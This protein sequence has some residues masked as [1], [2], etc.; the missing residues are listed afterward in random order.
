MERYFTF[1]VRPVEKTD[2]R[3]GTAVCRFTLIEL[4][5]VIAIIAILAAL[6]LPVLN[7]AR[8][9]SKGASCLNNKK[10]CI[11]ALGMYS[12]DF[13]GYFL[14]YEERGGVIKTWPTVLANNSITKF[15]GGPY[16]TPASVLCPSLE[17]IPHADPTDYNYWSRA[18]GMDFDGVNENLG[19]YI[20]SSWNYSY[21]NTKRMKKT[22]S[23]LVLADTAD[24]KNRVHVRFK[25]YTEF[26]CRVAAAHNKRISAAFADGS[27]R[28]NSGAELKNSEYALGVWK[29]ID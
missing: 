27:A 9:A 2:R 18:V 3:S 14:S 4:L 10:Q 23:I 11:Q 17:Y 16:L 6:L 22:S 7:K 20:T 29:N 8:V 5:V 13:G 12:D 28:M 26:E 19:D 25:R 1:V 15:G 21:L 24:T